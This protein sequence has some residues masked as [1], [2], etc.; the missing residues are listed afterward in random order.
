MSGVHSSPYKILGGKG[1]LAKWIVSWIRWGQVNLFVEPFLGGAHVLCSIP[2]LG[3]ARD[4]NAVVSD[5]DPNLCVLHHGASL[6]EDLFGPVHDLFRSY[7]EAMPRDNVELRRWFES[8]RD[9]LWENPGSSFYE[10]QRAMWAVCR[11]GF[12]GYQGSKKGGVR[13]DIEA[14]KLLLSGLGKLGW[15]QY[16][17]SNHVSHVYDTDAV[18]VLR[19]IEP[20][21]DGTMLV[22]LDPPYMTDM[23]TAAFYGSERE[24]GPWTAERIGQVVLTALSSEGRSVVM[25][26]HYANSVLDAVVRGV[27]DDA[28]CDVMYDERVSTTIRQ[29][30]ARPDGLWIIGRKNV[31]S[32]VVKTGKVSKAESR[33]VQVQL[34]LV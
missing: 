26:S 18:E 13:Y 4:V 19:G 21:G 12:G 11:L 29:E 25:L 17:M 24:T 32:R 22:Y 1:S 28:G 14:D 5:T 30:T 8:E 34:D 3:E 7:V 6:L 20:G 2:F 33:A 27:A 9:V 15:Y 10:V 23:R 31:L 16:V